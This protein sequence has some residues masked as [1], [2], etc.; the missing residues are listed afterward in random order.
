[1][2]MLEHLSKIQL[3]RYAGRTLNGEE[4]LAVDRHL[5][6]CDAC[7]A[8]F[9]SSLPGGLKVSASSFESME[10][11]FHLDYEQ[12]LK[13][14]VDGQANEIDRE[15]VASHV[16]LCATCAADLEDLQTFSKQPAQTQ[17]DDVP[18]VSPKLWK[19]GLPQWQRLPL[20]NSPFAVTF[21]VIVF[22]LG[23]TLAVLIW[24]MRPA[25][26]PV[27]QAGPTSQPEVDKPT[28]AI[29]PESP[30]PRSN[31]QTADE[32][33]GEPARQPPRKRSEQRYRG[34]QSLLALNDG[35]G[36]ITL[37]KQ[38]EMTGL[39]QLPPDLRETVAQVLTTR[40]FAVSPGLRDLTDGPRKLRGG[41]ERNSFRV[42]A[43]AGVVVESDRPTFRW[44]ALEGAQDYTVRIYD[45]E[46]RDVENS[47]PLDGTEWR[48]QK[49]LERGVIYSWQIRATKD[50][51]TVIAPKPPAPEARFR[52]L[53]QEAVAALENAKRLHSS[54]HLAMGV[55]YWKH[56]L[57]DEAER[58]FQ[59]LVSANPD[60]PV[61]ARLLESLR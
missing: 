49:P 9:A 48:I 57:I 51:E 27:Q 8:V 55:L 32:N 23:I 54:S 19:Q 35:G 33:A 3:A 15:I 44:S 2:T 17:G 13:P 53:D 16:A 41:E 38:G 6:S 28:P 10:E 4:L 26:G 24:T 5:A 52:V 11:P 45:S 34:E 42:L 39:E 60:S 47:G 50:G 43:P 30:A 61:A 36:R 22:I 7:Y 1:M 56:G 37:N 18:G 29:T 58:E 31:E 20:A 40:R 25:T 21:V 14:Y 46:L 59:A 12:H